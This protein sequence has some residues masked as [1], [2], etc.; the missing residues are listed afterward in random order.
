MEAWNVNPPDWMDGTA[1]CNTEMVERKVDT[2]VND[3]LSHPW[4]VTLGKTDAG[5]TQWKVRGGDFNGQG[6]SMSVANETFEMEDGFIYLTITRE[7]SSRVVTGVVLEADTTIPDSDNINQYV[8]IAV[9]DI[10][11]GYKEPKIIQEE[12][13][14]L[15]IQEVLI[16]ANGELALVPLRMAGRNPYPLP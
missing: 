2:A 3:Y 7:P 15:A 10:A 4:K 9:V 14:D 16:V 6:L 1:S 5:A 11:P 13:D 8:P 12:H